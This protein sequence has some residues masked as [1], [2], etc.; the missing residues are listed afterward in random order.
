MERMRAWADIE[1]PY[2]QR[3]GPQKLYITDPHNN[4]VMVTEEDEN[5]RRLVEKEVNLVTSHVYGEAG[6]HA[7]CLDIDLP[8]ELVPSRTPG[9]FHLY[10]EKAMPW[11][12]YEA[13][14]RAL[15][16]AGIIEE[17]YAGA[18][19]AK[20]ATCLRLPDGYYQERLRQIG[21]EAEALAR[22]IQ[23]QEDTF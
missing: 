22:E 10:I 11:H 19:I 3:K 23:D 6:Q 12:K 15:A 21:E 20:G 4:K 18:S 7:V 16:I 8:C 1:Q 2:D 5:G 17:G 13:L 9:H 14:L